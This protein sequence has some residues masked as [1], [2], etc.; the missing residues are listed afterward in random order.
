MQ[1]RL[2]L[3][4]EHKVDEERTARVRR[5]AVCAI[6]LLAGIVSGHQ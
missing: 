6:V 1:R 5:S 3:L 4:D 2:L